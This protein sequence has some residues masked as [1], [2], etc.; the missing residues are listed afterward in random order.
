MSTDWWEVGT[1]G[2]PDCLFDSRSLRSGFIS[3]L[4][5]WASQVFHLSLRFWIVVVVF[6]FISQHNWDKTWKQHQVRCYIL[7]LSQLWSTPQSSPNRVIS[8]FQNKGDSFVFIGGI[9]NLKSSQYLIVIIF[10]W[11]KVYFGISSL[12]QKKHNLTESCRRD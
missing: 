7:Q 3:G 6:T 9:G 5:W 8:T 10:L 12:R 11:Y 2:P 1:S 4:L